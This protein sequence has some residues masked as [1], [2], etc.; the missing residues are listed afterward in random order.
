[1]TDGAGTATE[2]E[3]ATPEPSE[4]DP[5]GFADDDDA[6]PESADGGTAQTLIKLLSRHPFTSLYE[7][8]AGQKLGLR[9]RICFL[10]DV[11]FVAIVVALLLG[12]IAAVAWKTLAPLPHV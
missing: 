3:V 2:A 6:I 10:L 9:G 4:A 8:T 7:K 11:I 5:A 12:I 1:M